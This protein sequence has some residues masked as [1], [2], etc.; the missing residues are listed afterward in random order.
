MGHFQSECNKE[1]YAK[2]NQLSNYKGKP[3]TEY[4]IIN[5][6]G[7]DVV[8]DS[9]ADCNLIHFDS[10][11][12]LD[13]VI[14]RKIK[15][16]LKGMG[17]EPIESCGEVK[18][19]VNNMGSLTDETFTVVREWR[20]DLEKPIMG[21]DFVL[22]NYV[23]PCRL[24][25]VQVTP[26]ILQLEEEWCNEVKEV[27]YSLFD[28]KLEKLVKECTWSDDNPTTMLGVKH[29]I[30]LESDAKPQY[31]YYREGN[32]EKF[33]AMLNEVDSMLKNDV[34]EKKPWSAKSWN[35]QPIMIPK[36]DGSWR[37]TSNL[38][39]LNKSVK[40]QKFDIPKE[41]ELVREAAEYK[42][43][44]KLDCAK[45]YWQIPLDVNSREYTAFSVER[46][47]KRQQYQYK[48]MP[49]GLVDSGFTYQKHM[50]HVLG[51]LVNVFVYIDDILVASDD[52]EEHVKL[53]AE[54][55]QR[56]KTF[57]IKVKI[58][59]CEFF[60]K[61]VEFLGGK[62]LKGRTT[63]KDGAV[64]HLLEMGAPK[65][66]DELRSWYATVNWWHK[67][68]PDVTRV[69]SPI[70]DLLKK[71]KKFKWE[72]IHEKAYDELLNMLKKVPDLYTPK[73]EDRIVLKTDA[74]LIGGGMALYVVRENEEGIDTLYPVCF[75]SVK[76]SSAQKNYS[77]GELEALTI[78]YAF[79]RW[80]GLLDR[81]TKKL[82]VYT[83]HLPLI[84]KPY[85]MEMVNS[86]RGKR[87]KRW[88]NML[89]EFRY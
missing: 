31:R 29:S 89:D 58:T 1:S 60:K 48:V 39:P 17:S 40:Y 6:V 81:P 24:G 67:Y 21:R 3:W 38:K 41:E 46:D 74:S 59:K 20:R 5:D 19:K 44:T 9:G 80:K 37:L 34:I 15:T 30:M 63:I 55:F 62:I 66:K 23:D 33:N 18:L 88:F 72:E 86:I 68:L 8:M 50:H 7:F 76:W 65:N 2:I 73:S 22:D 78:V 64:K 85:K 4:M 10:L 35:M 87:I 56:L 61:E 69:L 32:A 36:S 26:G 13:V 11:K 45:G 12:N 75:H 16:K 54:V 57:N 47:G 14:N 79:D 51:D 52:D 53:L 71:G 77:V 83:D 84:G 42:V 49:M 70:S 43:F 27:D 28:P 25:S 82:M